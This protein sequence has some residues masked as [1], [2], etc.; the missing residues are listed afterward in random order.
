VWEHL[1]GGFHGHSMTGRFVW[2]NWPVSMKF[3]IELL[4]SQNDQFNCVGNDL[5]AAERLLIQQ[6]LPCF[7]ISLN[8]LPTP[9]PPAYRPA[10][11]PLRCARSLT[12]LTYEAERAVKAEDHQIWLEEFEK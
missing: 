5:S 2:A 11:A 6:L 3:T 12:R 4:S 9:I 7:N 1:L 8:N 10:N